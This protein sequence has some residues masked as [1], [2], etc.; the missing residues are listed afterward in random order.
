MPWPIRQFLQAFRLMNRAMAR[1]ARQRRPGV[2][3]AWR[4][5]QL[6]FLLLNLRGLAEPDHYDRSV[7]DLL[8]F[9]TGGGKTEAYLGL[10]AF[11]LVL[12]RLRNP[13]IQAAGLAVLMRYTLRLLTLDQLGR[14]AA[15]ICALELER[16]ADPA[17]LGDWPF[18]IGLWVGQAATPNRMGRKGDDNAYTARYK[19]LQFQRNDRNPSPIPLEN[20][21]WCGEKF[22]A[23]FVP[24]GPPSR[25]AHRF[26]GGLRQPRLRLCRA[27]RA[28]LADPQRGRTD[29]PPPAGLSHRHGGQ[30][31]R[32]AVDRRGR[33]AV[34]PGGPVRRRRLLRPLPAQSGPA[35]ARQAACRRPN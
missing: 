12:R 2:D 9:P 34:W 24:T 28:H 19:T 18:E 3:P 25:R 29:L 8:F 21:P 33:R 30:V 26:A 16:Q 10:A 27:H 32:A 22:T 6:A 35:V 17:T 7:V 15:L 1:A 31:R 5:F 20:C 13:G 23:Q 11:T 4:P 14:A